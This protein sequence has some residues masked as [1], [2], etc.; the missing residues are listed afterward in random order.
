MFQ[1]TKNKP[2]KKK[3]NSCTVAS[4][5]LETARVWKKFEIPNVRLIG[6][7]KIYWKTNWR[8]YSYRF[9]IR[10]PIFDKYMTRLQ[11]QKGMW[12][13]FLLLWFLAFV[14]T[15]WNFFRIKPFKESLIHIIIHSCP[16]F[17]CSV[18]TL[19]CLNDEK[20]FSLFFTEVKRL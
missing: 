18:V 9:I 13:A 2:K 14:K 17:F 12:N 11:I 15:T 20:F 1:K 6:N 19:V 10:I 3:K 16:S 4:G 8:V 7:L 5:Y